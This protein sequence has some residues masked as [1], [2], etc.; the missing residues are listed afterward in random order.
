MKLSVITVVYNDIQNIEKTIKSVL[1][2]TY[3]NIEYIIVDGAST[4]GTTDVIKKYSNKISKFISE[5]D[6]GLYDAMNKGIDMLS[7]DYVCFLNSGDRFFDENTVENIFNTCQNQQ[8]DVYYG[9]TLI[10][11]EKGDIKGYRRLRAPENLSKKDFKHGM[12]VSHQAFIPSTKLIEKYDRRYKFSAD[13]DWT[14]KILNKAK[15]TCFV[16]KPLIL[17][18]DGGLTKKRLKESLRERFRIMKKNYGLIWTLWLHLVN[19]IKLL[20]FYLKNRWF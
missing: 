2:Q 16:K 10:V 8:I 3:K 7:G 4:D 14:I 12:L 17:F 20:F 18:L 19:G 5:A 13:Y 9:E 1:E 6:N 11:D 15:N